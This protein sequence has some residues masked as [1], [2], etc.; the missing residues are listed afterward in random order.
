MPVVNIQDYRCVPLDVL[1]N[2][3]KDGQVTIDVT[4][5]STS[6]KS[7]N[8]NTKQELYSSGA[9]AAKPFTAK[10]GEAIAITFGVLAAIFLTVL[11]FYIGPGN[12]IRFLTRNK[13]AFY[14]FFSLVIGGAIATIICGALLFVGIL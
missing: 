11:F 7:I 9:L 4:P 14:S 3:D 5:E 12:L 10:Q 2:V 6:L 1:Q 13:I 8:D